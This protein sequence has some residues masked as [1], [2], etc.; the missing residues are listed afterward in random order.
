MAVDESL[1]PSGSFVMARGAE[2]AVKADGVAS[3]WP[4]PSGAGGGVIWPDS[5]QCPSI[6]HRVTPAPVAAIG[7]KLS[8]PRT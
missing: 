6:K 2:A 5:D 1:I 4:A 8:D 7:D 3:A